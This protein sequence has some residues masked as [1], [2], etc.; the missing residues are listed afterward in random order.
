MHKSYRHKIG[1]GISALLILLIMVYSLMNWSFLTSCLII[2]CLT[3]LGLAVRTRPALGI[4]IIRRVLIFIPTFLLVSILAFFISQN[5]PY[6]PVDSMMSSLSGNGTMDKSAAVMEDRNK[7]RAQLG[8]NHPVF[9][10]KLG[11]LAECDTLYKIT[12]KIHQENLDHLTHRYGNWEE[13][14]TYYKASLSCLN[15]AKKIQVDSIYEASSSFVHPEVHVDTMMKIVYNKYFHRYWDSSLTA[16]NVN[17]TL[18]AIGVS[19]MLDTNEQYNLEVR[20]DSLFMVGS[21]YNR[22]FGM[23]VYQ[24]DSLIRD[25]T[26]RKD[27]SKQYQLNVNSINESK[28]TLINGYNKLLSTADEK[29]VQQTFDSLTVM[30]DSALFLSHAK[31]GFENLKSAERKMREE[32]SRWKNFVP[33]ITWNGLSNQYHNWLFGTKSWFDTN[34]KGKLGLLRGDFGVS[35]QTGQPVKANLIRKFRI[36]VELV[37]MAIFIAYLV[38]IPIGIYAAYRRNSWFDKGSGIVL[39]VLYSLPNFFV[40]LML[41]NLF[42][43]P[44]NFEWFYANGFRPDGMTDKQYF[45]D[46]N[47]WERLK[48]SW[49]YMILPLATYTYAMFAFISRIMRVGMLESL[50]QDYI[51]TARAK[52]LSER[53][54]ILKHALKNSLL[55]IITIFANV[56]PL[57]IGGSVI[58]EMIFD[59]Q[60]MGSLTLE[61]IYNGDYPV[62]ISIFCIAGLL[63]MVG[64]LVSDI[65]YAVVDPRI[66]LNNKS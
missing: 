5:S 50:E 33:A 47:Y 13:I 59:Y 38:S 52:G 12:H 2:T 34:S 65:L 51:R 27:S 62:I 54:V 19:D 4:Y 7:L 23:R 20:N 63:T 3:L 58:I 18:M 16:F 1:L 53:K 14:A 49:P 30:F 15:T 17:D 44:D 46:L 43:N 41:I 36:S 26:F 45:E 61:A 37:L 42:A 10:F 64:Y 25:Y 31:P 6:D 22:Y 56:F 29:A 9:Y 66:S 55:P 39:F 40:G 60:G 21:H 24:K 11:T 28:N 35:F 8:L 57:A 48:M 32:S